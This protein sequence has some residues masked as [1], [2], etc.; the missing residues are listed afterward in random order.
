MKLVVRV[1]S[2]RW[3]ERSC[4]A[5]FD[6]ALDCVPTDSDDVLYCMVCL[7]EKSLATKKDGRLIGEPAVLL[8]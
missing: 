4:G 6:L 3:H 2:H 8:Y 7:S 5:C 1:R